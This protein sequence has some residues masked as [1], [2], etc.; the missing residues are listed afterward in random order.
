MKCWKK[1]QKKSKLINEKKN[2]KKI[3]KK[4][5]TIVDE[6]IILK[7]II[8]YIYCIIDDCIKNKTILYCLILAGSFLFSTFNCFFYLQPL[9]MS[10][11]VR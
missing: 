10:F 5:K 4:K 6:L 8:K 3:K 9:T 11:E 1:K 7:K 2:K